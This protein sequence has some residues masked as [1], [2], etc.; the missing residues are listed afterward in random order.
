VALYAGLSGWAYPEWRPAFYP[1]GMPTAKMLPFYAGSFNTVEINNTFYRTPKPEAIVGWCSQVPPHFRFSVKV[2]RAITHRK[3]FA[4]TTEFFD[5]NVEL[6]KTIGPL[7]GPVLFQF[8][9]IAD[10]PQL[11]DFLVTVKRHF[12]RVVVE[13]RHP[14]W[15]TDATFDALRAA[16]VAMCQTETDD[17]CD[18]DVSATGFSYLRLRRSSYTAAELRGRLDALRVLAAERDAFVYLKHDVENAVLLR[19]LL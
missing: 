1:A 5:A 19:Q 13:F 18:P 6:L 15:L 9:T 4:A 10:V 17:G 3:G 16:D 2:H 12:A 8:E 11:A 7:L 14:S